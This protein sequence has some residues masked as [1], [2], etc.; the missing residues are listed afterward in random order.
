MKSNKNHKKEALYTSQK[1]GGGKI[2]LEVINYRTAD[3][4]LV[5]LLAFIGSANHLG[6]W[7]KL[8]SD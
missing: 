6:D 1:R 3:L 7:N 8:V 4:M 2:I 5:G